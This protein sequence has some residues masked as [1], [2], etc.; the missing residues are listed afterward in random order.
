M[1]LPLDPGSPSASG[2]VARTLSLGLLH[3][4]RAEAGPAE[5]VGPVHV[6]NRGR[7]QH[8][9][10]RRHRAYDIADREGRLVLAVAI[11][12]GDIA[13]VARLGMRR[14]D[15]AFEEGERIGRATV[16]EIGIVDLETCRQMIDED[17]PGISR[18]ALSDLQADN[19]PVV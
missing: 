9:T 13:I 12:R 6:L 7:R 14:L 8:V 15:I 3:D 18:L 2:D 11:E 17:E 16:E 19:K 10:P 4:Q 1:H 5:A